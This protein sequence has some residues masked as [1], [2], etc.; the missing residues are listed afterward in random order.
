MA[1]HPPRIAII[2][3]ATSGIGEATAT[4]FIASGYGVVGNGR[5]AEKLQALEQALGAAFRGV[6][7]DAGDRAVLERLFAMDRKTLL[8][9]AGRHRRRE[10][11]ARL[12]APS[13]M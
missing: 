13:G 12:V 8:V 9:R 10:C 11:R 1:N 2:T 5:N 4:T 6:A 7:G 3:G